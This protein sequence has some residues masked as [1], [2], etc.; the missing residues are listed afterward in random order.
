VKRQKLRFVKHSAANS[1]A[2]V[3]PGGKVSPDRYADKL[4]NDYRPA[5]FNGGSY[6]A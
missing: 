3:G 2:G 1:C 5:R 4:G 6:R